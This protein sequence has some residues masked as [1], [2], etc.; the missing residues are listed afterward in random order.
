MKSASHRNLTSKL[1]PLFSGGAVLS[2]ANCNC[3]ATRRTLLKGL[4]LLGAGALFPSSRA[5]AA[6]TPAKVNR[7]NV[8]HH[9]APPVWMSTMAAKK[10]LPQPRVWNRW[11]EQSCLDDMDKAGVDVAILSVT[12]P[13]IWVGDIEGTRKLARECNEYAAKLVDKY[14]GRYGMFVTVPQLSDIDGTL[15]EIAYGMDVLKAD[16]VG[17]FTSYE[18]KYLGD[19]AWAPI[20]EE[21]NRRKAILYTHPN[22]PACCANVDSGMQPSAIEYGTD[23]TRAIA[24]MVYS[25]TGR[26]YSDMR[27]IF[28][29]AGGTMPFLYERFQV[30]MRLPDKADLPRDTLEV[31]KTFYY[32]TAQ[33]SNP[34]T[35]SALRKLVPV[36]QILFG[37]DFPFRTSEEHVR[38]LKEGGVFTADEL[39]AIYR[40]NPL[41]LLP[42]YGA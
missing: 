36:S 7:I 2:G 13:G 31:I 28:S 29:H 39:R 6:E 34:I 14:K 27:V 25:G 17:V 21:L 23:T 15:K 18:G 24:K 37:T 30:E 35:M 9:L 4:A 40:D 12:T 3:C 20:Y 5:F 32:D 38:A 26:K 41:R 10:I 22:I 42:K 1:D 19:P 33:S 11:S 8:H 16:G